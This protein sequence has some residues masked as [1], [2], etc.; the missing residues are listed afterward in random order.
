MLIREIHW[1]KPYR[2]YPAGFALELKDRV[3]VIVGDNGAGKSTLL[4]LLRGKFDSHWTPSSLSGRDWED[5]LRIEPPVPEGEPLTYVDLVADHM[6]NRSEF[7]TEHL[8]L[9]VKAMGKSAGQ[10][11]M[12]QLTG[13]MN[14]SKA[15]VHLI[16]EP[17]RGLSPSKQWVIAAA[18]KQITLERPDDQFLITTHSPQFMRTLS[19]SEVLALP[20]G[21]YLPYEDY[22]ELADA[23]GKLL[24][25]RYLK[26][27]GLDR[28]EAAA[29][30]MG[31]S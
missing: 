17:E 4:G 29:A 24:A 3:T 28:E 9:Q 27:R 31:G 15:R 23:N 8:D 25:E 6:G 21:T 1:R 14:T 19:N 13:L 10:T 7:D 5:V 11:S 12:I 2:N 16:D 18:L 22:L 26:A 20:D 30:K